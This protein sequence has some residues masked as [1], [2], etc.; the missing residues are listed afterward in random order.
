MAALTESF[1]L[2]P[3]PDI[4]S[5]PPQ[6]VA[7][8]TRQKRTRRVFLDDTTSSDPPYFSSDDIQEASLDDYASKRNKRFHRGTWWDYGDAVET[9]REENAIKRCVDS[10]VW[11]GSDSTDDSTASLPQPYQRTRRPFV[12]TASAVIQ[13]LSAQEARAQREVLYCLER[14]DEKIDLS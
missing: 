2:E 4:P 9:P 3:S 11:M 7:F 1:S 5:S 12:R 10:G 13:D 8:P 14:G 6:L